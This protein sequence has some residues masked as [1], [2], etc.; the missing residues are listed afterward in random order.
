MAEATR[1][2]GLVAP[3]VA[4][5]AA[6]GY[7]LLLFAVAFW[8]DRRA[9]QHRSVIDRSW[10][11]SLSIGVYCT[12]WTFFGSV[13][14]AAERGLW[15]LPIYLGPTLVMLAA[16]L[17]LVPM[18]RV[19]KSLRLTSLSDLLSTRFGH[20][21]LLGR[22]VALA[23]VVVSIP[24]VALQLKAIAL[25]FEIVSGG[26]GG[27]AARTFWLVVVLALFA[28]LFGTR[29]LDVTERHEGLVAAVAF[30]SAVKLGAFLLLGVVIGAVL[31]GDAEGALRAAWWEA[32]QAV[33]KIDAVA[34][35]GYG[36]WLALIVL[37]GVAFL[38]LPRQ[39]Q[40]L[41]VEN[42]RAEHLTRASWQFPL[43][44]WALNLF[45]VPV[46]LLGKVLLPDGVTSD[47]F[48]LTVPLAL[49]EHWLAVVVFLGGI[50][51]ATSMVIVES[52]ALAT[53]I[54]N[55]WVA[56]WW[57]RRGK[58][59]AAGHLLWVRRAVIVAVIA[60]GYLFFLLAG[61]SHA[62]IAIGLVSFL[63]V[64]QLAPA[65]VAAFLWPGASAVGVAAGLF[66]GLVVWGYTA[67]LPLLIRSGWFPEAW[68]TVGPA[69]I[70]WLR[71]EAL[72][73]VEGMAPVTASL[74]WSVLANGVVLIAVS[75]LRPPDGAT[76]AIARRFVADPLFR[77]S[78]KGA[79]TI[80]DA[81]V[82]PVRS[83]WRAKTQ[84]SAVLE[85]LARFVS[86]ERLEEALRAFR[87]ERGL[88]ADAPLVVDEAFVAFAERLLSGAIGGV[89]ARLVLEGVL[90]E[91]AP[92]WDEVMALVDEARAVREANERLREL[93]R[94]KDEFIASVSHELRT[95]LTAVRA[96]AELLAADPDIDRE[97]RRK[98]YQT[99]VRESER[100]TRL[101]N[102]V[103]DLAKLDSGHA[104]WR[105]EAV[106][107]RTV[108]HEVAE[109]MRPVV[110]ERGGE[111]RVVVPQEE[112]ICFG[113]RDRLVQLLL[114][115]VGNAV[116]FMKV[117]HGKVAVTLQPDAQTWRLI[118]EDNG[119]GVP[120]EER[121]AIFERFHRVS[122]TRAHST[123][124]GLG[125]AIAKR[126][127]E[128][129]GGAIAVDESPL[130][131]ARF[132][133]TLPRGTV[134]QE[135]REREDEPQNFGGG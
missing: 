131:G 122:K 114:N 60:A 74:V 95:P 18:L 97:T 54:S 81:S 56:P 83:H 94:M 40:V 13:G 52:V 10:V 112:A 3:G 91:R 27:E 36:D 35:M 132:V 127:A 98:F 63:G 78:R 129:M 28:A 45:V 41:V 33:P 85:V 32:W 65:V 87:A 26:A 23:L 121:Q 55:D 115:L 16:P 29:R 99:M 49:H 89:A 75:V 119:P 116:Q 11:Y 69:G 109:T 77:A 34:A 84:S 73:G 5:A 24:Y 31:L 134:S 120:P 101:V 38:L 82:A 8:A 113:D 92:A 104:E 102:Q 2:L 128:H 66:V 12:A 64:A 107:L 105:H 19:A 72:F 79:A 86:A 58:T 70:A 61:E 4:A 39:F 125:L 53:M 117:P 103:L 93:D 42:V 100:L 118:V 111:L 15:F 17:V 20:R 25:A 51:A 76:R 106:D 135:N 47:G 59:L 14:V 110:R 30:E 43:Y 71:P 9:A 130:G 37:A 90:G 124:T 44:L 126:I 21:A 88:A 6:F 123:G 22:W 96:Y 133:V 7:L 80:A 67:L 108:V 68:L 1:G 50:S 48:V 46:A 62:L 57:L